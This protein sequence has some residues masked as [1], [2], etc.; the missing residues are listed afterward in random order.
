MPATRWAKIHLIFKPQA[1]QFPAV[2][3]E[4]IMDRDGQLA[5]SGTEGYCVASLLLPSIG[6]I[7][8]VSIFLVLVFGTGNGLL[9]DGDTGYHIRTGEEILRTWG[10]PTHDLYSAHVPPLRWTTHEWLAEVIM[11]S[12]FKLSGLTGLVLC[13]A[14][15]LSAIHWLLFLILR[16]KSENLVL[17]TLI[18]FLAT[19]SSSNHWLARP[20]VFSLLFTLVWCYLLDRFQYQNDRTLRFL[21]VSMLFW[22]NL[23]GGFIIGLVLLLVYLTG[24]FIHSFFGLPQESRENRKK[25]KLLLGV[26]FI[27]I[28]TCLINPFG[29]KI[30]L[31]PFTLASDR[32]VMDHV[33]EFMSPNFHEALPFKYMLLAIIGT[34]A[35]SRTPFNLIEVGLLLLLSYMTLYSARHVSLFAIVISPLL[36][37][38]SEQVYAALP[39]WIIKFCQTR[40]QNLAQIDKKVTGY[41]WPATSILCVITLAIFGNLKFEFNDKRFPVAAVEFLKHETLQGKMFNNDEFGDYMI[42]KVWPKYRVF[43][44]GRSDMYGAKLGASYLTVANVLPG[45][46]EVLSR[47]NISWII[48]DTN[49]ALTA[50]LADDSAWQAIYSDKVASIFLRKDGANKSLLG[51]YHAV[52]LSASK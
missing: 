18:A 12:V 15:L 23:H 37:K 49:S 8:F 46:K 7:V 31:F 34:L 19:A 4:V 24:N 10:I 33:T 41:I 35:L 22:V 11:A 5:S 38:S 32:F 48:F 51:K 44:D 39:G 1:G 50:A 9:Y 52:V 2:E 40:N 47:H 20:H 25:A 21:P 43:M 26:F 3:P 29:Y 45:W 27:T 28:L 14:V 42:Y 30:L 16:S 17:V 6:N 36:L 13:F